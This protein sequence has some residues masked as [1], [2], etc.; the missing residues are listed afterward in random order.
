VTGKIMNNLV[1][2]NR[3]KPYYYRDELP[4][5]PDTFEDNEIL[6]KDRNPKM[7]EEQAIIPTKMMVVPERKGQRVKDSGRPQNE[8]G[9][10]VSNIKENGTEIGR[11]VQTEPEMLPNTP[12]EDTEEA[13]L[14]DMD[15]M[16]EAECILKQKAKR[17]EKKFLER[18]ID[19][20]A[21]DTWTVESDLSD[22][23]LLHWW[24]THTRVGLKRKGLK[25]SLL[26][27]PGAWAYQRIG[28]GNDNSVSG[29]T[30]QVEKEGGSDDG[31]QKAARRRRMSASSTLGRIDL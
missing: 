22:V 15:F 27:A 9:T 6:V 5:D 25:V 1:H 2:I 18:W 7:G 26:R 4:E 10:G 28:Q 23:R 16:Y 29:C 17:G 21:E 30:D 24:T 19:K 11:S 13:K 12:E 3:I 14:P 31:T 20:N 8:K